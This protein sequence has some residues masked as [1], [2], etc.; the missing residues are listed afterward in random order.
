M[1]LGWTFLYAFLTFIVFITLLLGGASLITG[2][3][4]RDR[5]LIIFGLKAL[6]ITILAAAIL[7]GLF[8]HQITGWL[9]R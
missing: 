8:W 5:S 3:I 2:S 4:K 7:L 1:T 6:L 9:S